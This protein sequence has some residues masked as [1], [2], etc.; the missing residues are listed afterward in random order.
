MITFGVQQPGETTP[1]YYGII[2]ITLTPKRAFQVAYLED[3]A[4]IDAIPLIYF[5]EYSNRFLL[6]Y[7]DAC[8][9]YDAF[10]NNDREM[11]TYYNLKLP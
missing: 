2:G 7:D 5:K 11:L 1:R 3:G 10:K 4:G 6:D 9:I 8:A